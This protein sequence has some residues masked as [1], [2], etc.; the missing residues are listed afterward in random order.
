VLVGSAKKA[1]LIDTKTAR[2]S[3]THTGL[4]LVVPRNKR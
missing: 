3:D 2:F 1:G 4:K